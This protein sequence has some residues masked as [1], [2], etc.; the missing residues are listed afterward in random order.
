MW[1]WDCQGAWGRRSFFPGYFLLHL[2]GV[3]SWEGRKGGW[4]QTSGRQ[5]VSPKLCP[6]RG[7]VTCRIPRP[8][9]P[10]SSPAMGQWG[11]GIFWASAPAPFPQTLAYQSSS[12]L[13]SL[14]AGWW[15]M[16]K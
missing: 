14:A 15:V 2:T 10:V 12:E 11:D 5:P 9:T 6:Q 7:W 16:D 4:V 13:S 8:G 3:P 1:A